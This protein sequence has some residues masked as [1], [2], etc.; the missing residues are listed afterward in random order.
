MNSRTS[1]ASLLRKF[2][3]LSFMGLVAM[4]AL[5]ESPVTVIEQGAQELGEKL[6]GR[7]DELKN[8]K[9]ALYAL[10]DE[11]LLPR[12]DR[13]YAARLVLGRHWRSASEPQQQRFIAAFYQALLRRYADGVLE[14]DSSRVEIMPYRGDDQEKR[15]TVRTTVTLDDGTK[16]PV[17]Y[18][19]VRRDTG[20]L[21]FDVT[22]EGISYVRNFRAEM[23]SEIQAKGLESVIKRLESE[24]EISE[25]S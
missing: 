25:V 8:D 12:F 19:L 24:A 6:E 15:T 14:Y 20:W 7:R 2:A 9:T 4:S 1:A 5:A 16:V 10:I 3:L 22:I 23:N 11:M 21:M 13:E 17:N 18:A